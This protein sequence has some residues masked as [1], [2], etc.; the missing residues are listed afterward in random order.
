M[1]G[2]VGKGNYSLHVKHTPDVGADVEKQS[3]QEEKVKKSSAG[4]GEG[5][6]G[7]KFEGRSQDTGYRSQRHPSIMGEEMCLSKIK[8]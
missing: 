8:G 1:W 3:L 4:G 2:E 6:W 7:G 5:A